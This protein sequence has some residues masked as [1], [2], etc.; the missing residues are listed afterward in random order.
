[1][2]TDVASEDFLHPM[3]LSARTPSP[4]CNSESLVHA[5]NLSGSHDSDDQWEERPC[6]PIL[7]LVP[8]PFLVGWLIPSLFLVGCWEEP[9]ALGNW[10]SIEPTGPKSQPLEVEILR[11]CGLVASAAASVA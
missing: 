2:H 4:H 5:S 6:F 10:E 7:W 9:V 1:M 8:F 3:L 11:G